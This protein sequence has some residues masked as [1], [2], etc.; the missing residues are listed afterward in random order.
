MGPL[1]VSLSAASLACI[2]FLSLQPVHITKMVVIVISISICSSISITIAKAIAMTTA[3]A[4]A[5][6]AVDGPATKIAT[7]YQTG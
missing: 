4:M 2:R 3:T 7:F 6:A 1:R 5:T